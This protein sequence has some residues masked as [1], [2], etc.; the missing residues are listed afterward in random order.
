MIFKIVARDAWAAACRDGFFAGSPDDERDGFIHLSAPK[1]V[2]ETASKYFRGRSDLVLVAF[3]EAAL[4]GALLW[5]PAR[6]GQLFPH[7]YGPLPTALALWERP[8]SLSDQG[9]PEIPEDLL[10]C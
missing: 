3:D 10:R 4:G 6:G 8:L 5:E 1:Q 9:E 2:R 7:L